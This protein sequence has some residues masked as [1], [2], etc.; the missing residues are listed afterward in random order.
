MTTFKS[1][2]FLKS[3][4][5]RH[6]ILNHVFEFKKRIKWCFKVKRTNITSINTSNWDMTIGFKNKETGKIFCF[7]DKRQ[8]III[9]K[10]GECLFTGSMINRDH[11]HDKGNTFILRLRKNAFTLNNH[12]IHTL[13]IHQWHQ[14]IVYVKKGAVIKLFNFQID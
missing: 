4:F 11:M 12:H 9:G 13:N 6:S 7:N 3:N 2:L 10:K 5:G 14:L 1:N 8:K